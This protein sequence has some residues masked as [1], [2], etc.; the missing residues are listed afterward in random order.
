MDE[1]AEAAARRTAGA[2]WRVLLGYARPHWRMLLLGGVLSLATAASGLALPLVVRELIGT[3]GTDRPVA[4]LVALMSVLV[5]ANAAIGALG[6][7]VLRRTAETVVLAAR[8][9][10]LAR[11]LR[12]RLSAV[13][14]H[15]P[16]DLMSRV[17]SDT[18]LLREV[19]IG[20]L[21]GGVTGFLTLLRDHRADGAARPR[22]ARRDPGAPSG[23]RSSSSASWCPAS[24]GPRSAPRSRSA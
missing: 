1:G 3:L 22:H 4:G 5:V 6:G 19:T 16:G 8:R 7:Y 13:E 9:G 10:L 24:T 20:T 15:E 23:W 21:V 11:L 12:L 2:T 14:R 18:T 17:T